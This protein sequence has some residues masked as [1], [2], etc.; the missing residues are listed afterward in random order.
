MK[1]TAWK[2]LSTF[3][4][5][6]HE[7]DGSPVKHGDSFTLLA[8]HDDGRIEFDDWCPVVKIDPDGKGFKMMGFN[9][10]IRVSRYF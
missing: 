9:A 7:Y 10:D 3:A 8:V 6:L 1:I 5:E 2:N 4:R